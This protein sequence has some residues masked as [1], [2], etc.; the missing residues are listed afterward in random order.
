MQAP[1]VVGYTPPGHGICGPI[2]LGNVVRQPRH[3]QNRRWGRRGDLEELDLLAVV[4]GHQKRHRRWVTSKSVWPS[5]LEIIF[6]S[7]SFTRGF[8]ACCAMPASKKDLL[9]PQV[10]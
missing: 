5:R 10:H 1:R 4:A 6:G 3:L 9:A 8:L 2:D 7:G